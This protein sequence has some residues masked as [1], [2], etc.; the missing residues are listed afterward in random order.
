MP[1]GKRGGAYIRVIPRPL[2][3]STV[4]MT[5]PIGPNTTEAD[6]AK[7]LEQEFTDLIKLAR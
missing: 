2:G 4:S 5:V 3:R 7:I 6:V 1:G